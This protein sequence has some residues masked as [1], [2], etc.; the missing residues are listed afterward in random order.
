MGEI[1]AEGRLT[2]FY[3]RELNEILQN[4]LRF[5]FIVACLVAAITLFSFTDNETEVTEVSDNESLK[6][7][8]ASNDKSKINK[9]SAKNTSDKP[10][11]KVTNITGLER[12]SEGGELIN[13]FKSDL[14]KPTIETKSPKPESIPLPQIPNPA[15]TKT[16]ENSKKIVL[17]LKGTAISGDK[18][19]AIIQRSII[20]SNE[21]KESE[22]P[23]L[24]SIMVKIGDKIDN[25]IIIDIGK[26]FIVFD[27]GRHLTLQ[28]GL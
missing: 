21:K 3:D 18:K 8:A 11:S 9:T 15:S 7:A 2:E 27:D 17:I 22:K 13:P 23:K 24:E 10:T 12:A 28:E 20:K 19:M 25:N 5:G 16:T 6:V 4:K 26:N 14:V 1:V